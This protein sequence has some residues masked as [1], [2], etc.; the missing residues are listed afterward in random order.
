MPPT[1]TTT[2]PI[3]FYECD[4][5]GHLN[6]A[7]YVR[8]MQ[9][10]AFDA[11]DAVGFGKATYEAMGYVWL[12]H[13]TQ[14]EYLQPVQYGD[15]LEITTWVADFRQVRSLRRYEFRKA[16]S[17]DLVARASTDW[18]YV[19]RETGRLATIP[20]EMIAAFAGDDPVVTLPRPAYPTPPPAPTGVYKLVKRVEWRDIDSAQHMNNAAYLN[21]IEDA[22]LQVARHFHWPLTRAAQEGVGVFA[23]RHHVAYRQP[24]LLDDEL[25]ISTW[26]FDVKRFSAVRHFDIKRV[27]DNLLLAQVQ[28]YWIFI[29][30]ETG[31]P[32]R[33][34]QH[35]LDDLAPN[36]AE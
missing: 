7:N 36:I 2:Y 10:A 28:T 20:P 33:V 11:A 31:K 35:Y 19:N 26:L 5:Y 15:Q 17:P 16:G 9:E 6:H 24:A 27:S 34:P 21:Y 22:G 4:T 30:L 32:M 8:L 14:I 3:R 1:S 29:D 18:V 25:E 13:E 12:A 23:R